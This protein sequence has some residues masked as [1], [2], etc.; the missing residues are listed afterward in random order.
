MSERK[1]A[2][3]AFPQFGIHEQ[4]YAEHVD[5]VEALAV[6]SKAQ[7]MLSYF[8]GDRDFLRHTI[9]YGARY[10]DLGKLLDDCQEVLKGKTNRRQMLNHVDAGVAY[11]KDLYNKKGHAEFLFAAIIVQ[12]H[13]IG[14]LHCRE[15]DTKKEG[16]GW[17]IHHIKNP[18][19]YPYYLRDTRKINEH[20]S[21]L[22]SSQ[23]VCDYTDANL[24]ML[25]HHHANE[26]NK[27]D[28]KLLLR[29]EEKIE[30]SSLDFRLAASCVIDA[31]HADTARSN[32]G[33]SV[34]IDE[35]TYQL[36]ADKRFKNLVN[37]EKHDGAVSKNS[38]AY[39]IR[40]K[41]FC[42]CS[43]ATYNHGLY[44]CDATVGSGKTTATLAGALKAARDNGLRRVFYVAPFTNIID[45]VVNE[46]R[47]YVLLDNE[48]GNHHSEKVVAAHHHRNDYNDQIVK[49]FSVVWE[50]PIVVTTAVQFFESLGSN[51]TV[52]IKKLH[53]VP[54]SAIIIDEFHD[55]MPPKDWPLAWQWIQELIT[56]WGCHVFLSSGSPIQFWDIEDLNETTHFRPQNLL[57]NDTRRL[58]DRRNKRSRG[59]VRF[60]YEE[61]PYNPDNFD[62]LIHANNKKG[63]FL[64]VC[65]TVLNAA[66]LAQKYKI[67]Y[68]EDK[69]EHLSTA[70]TPLDRRQ[71]LQRVKRRLDDPN[72]NDWVLFATSCIE[73]G[74]NLDFMTGLVEARSV[75]A[76]DQVS[77]RVNRHGSYETRPVIVFTLDTSHPW[78]NENPAFRQSANILFDLLKQENCNLRPEHCTDAMREE[79]SRRGGFKSFVDNLLRYEENLL[80]RDVEENMN[81]IEDYSTPI[82]MGPAKRHNH[83]EIKKDKDKGI[84]EHDVFTMIATQDLNGYPLKSFE[85]Y[86]NIM[87]LSCAIPD[88]IKK[89]NSTDS[90]DVAYKAVSLES[91]IEQNVN[92]KG[93]YRLDPMSFR[94]WQGSY[95]PFFLGYMSE[96]LYWLGVPDVER[97]HFSDDNLRLAIDGR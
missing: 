52:P 12:G 41:L 22:T 71:T 6:L 44:L 36:R 4:T 13:H 56:K 45:Q 15:D 91:V 78:L 77:G 66:V 74:I 96:V 37:A 87:E 97:A 28:K 8:S 95:D 14:F 62:E 32:A 75:M 7:N 25:L 23:R 24:G 93:S 67:I 39:R 33:Y 5:N 49:T 2:H 47:Q 88:A 55:A 26:L 79:I 57:A 38:L 18:D 50:S 72:D 59:R 70:L 48:T 82:Y 30:V 89:I 84:Y 10:H 40:N 53:Q 60:R 27:P 73:S 92:E 46:F 17:N 3:S 19:S 61:K 29:S 85:V 58:I 43:N 80:I 63:P 69:V 21:H 94:L 35:N 64:V 11:L 54:G 83:W 16:S 9:E 31:D 42:D 51:R 90:K 86:K 76:L 81:V 1:A 34:D 68:G 65:N 20:Y